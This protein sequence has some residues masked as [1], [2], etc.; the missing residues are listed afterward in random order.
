MPEPDQKDENQKSGIAY[1]A[2]LSFFFAVA[3][4]CAL[5]GL[6]DRWLKTSPRFLVIGVVLGAIAG[7]YQFIR[8]TSKL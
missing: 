8:L 6:L 3:G 1:G 4:F 5:G 2:G 7:F